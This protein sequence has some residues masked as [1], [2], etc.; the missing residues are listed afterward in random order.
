MDAPPG[1]RAKLIA[2]AQA[3]LEQTFV[4]AAGLRVV[5]RMA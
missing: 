2:V 4:K 3:G 1:A 5:A